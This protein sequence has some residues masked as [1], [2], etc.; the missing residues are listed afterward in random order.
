[1]YR[2]SFS[3]RFAGIAICLCLF[4]TIACAQQS[5]FNVPS[6]EI[7]PKGKLFFQQQVN[8]SSII[9]LNTTLDYGLKHDWEIGVNLLGIDYSPSLHDFLKNDVLQNDPFS[10]LVM[11]NVQ[12][13]VPVNEHWKLGFGAQNGV[14]MAQYRSERLAYFY[15]ANAVWTSRSE[16]LRINSGLYLGNEHYLGDGNNVGVMVGA[17]A[18]LIPHKV[19]LM[20]DW[21]NGTHDLGVGVIGAVAYPWRH[22]PISL[23]WQLPNDRQNQ[24]AFVFEI[25]YI[26]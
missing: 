10:P 7:T 12:K 17:E 21:I 6:S 16:R 4:T 11:I 8:F 24:R 5:L 18:A 1:M 13:G 23:G 3:I 2:P 22:L 19:H 14:N 15:Y 26:P 25:T 20:A 9:Q